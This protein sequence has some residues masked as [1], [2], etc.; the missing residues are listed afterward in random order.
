[1]MFGLLLSSANICHVSAVVADAMLLC[2]AV[3]GLSDARRLAV[4][5]VSVGS[6]GRGPQREGQALRSAPRHLMSS[7]LPTVWSCYSV[8]EPPPPVLGQSWDM[9]LVKLFRESVPHLWAQIIVFT[10][11]SNFMYTPIN[12]GANYQMQT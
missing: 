3:S 7:P 9:R 5:E 12:K 10:L 1:M 4:M 8:V 2:R 6:K 11:G